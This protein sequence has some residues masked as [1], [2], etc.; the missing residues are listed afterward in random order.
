MAYLPPD[1]PYCGKATSLSISGPGSEVRHCFWKA[2]CNNKDFWNETSEASF[3]VPLMALLIS[4]ILR[5]ETQ[6]WDVNWEPQ[7][8]WPFHRSLYMVSPFIFCSEERDARE[9][10]MYEKQR[11]ISLMFSKL[12]RA[13][14]W[15]RPSCGI[16]PWGKCGRSYHKS[17]PERTNTLLL[18]WSYEGEVEGHGQM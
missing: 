6:Q 11:S 15:Q 18:Q 13:H 17:I 16:M 4:V 5:R 14:F 1:G 8:K 7:E 2:N 3:S 12:G 10:I 9:W